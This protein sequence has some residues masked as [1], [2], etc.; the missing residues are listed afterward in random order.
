M[1]TASCWAVLAVLLWG[2]LVVRPRPPRWVRWRPRANESTAE[3]FVP[4]IESIATAIA[5]GAAPSAACAAACAASVDGR[6]ARRD[7]DLERLAAD[8]RAGHDLGESWTAVAGRRDCDGLRAVAACWTL[9]E[10]VGSPLTESLAVAGQL[11]RAEAARDAAT[12]VAVAAPRASMNLLTA[13]PVLGV[14]AATALG[15][16]LPSVYL[17]PLAVV[18]VVPGVL[19]V[20]LGRRWSA[21]L[22]A[23]SMR[24][25]VLP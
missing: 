16:D 21:R 10:R 11:L 8:A 17:S 6:D 23:R 20:L 24:V 1:L 18:T 25:T 2:G 22:I 12:Q 19:L 15:A 4:V 3:V 7:A 14:V 13:L 5:G 9:S